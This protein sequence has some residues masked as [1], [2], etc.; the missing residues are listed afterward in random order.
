MAIKRKAIVDFVKSHGFTGEPKDEAILAYIA[1]N[2]IEFKTAKGEPIDVKS[3]LA[4][5]VSTVID[6]DDAGDSDDGEDENTTHL[7]AME[8]KIAEYE[9]RDA[10]RAAKSDGVAKWTKANAGGTG[11]RGSLRMADADRVAVKSYDRRVARKEA[12]YENGDTALAAGAFMR[13]AI[14][15]NRDYEMKARDLEI[16]AH[17]GVKT[18]VTYDGGLGGFTVPPE[19]I[20]TWIDLR[21]RY[22][23]ATSVLNQIDMAN[24]TVQIPRRTAGLTVYTPGEAG[25]ITP[26]DIGVDLVTVTTTKRAAA[27][28]ISSE[29]LNDSTAN[30]ADKMTEEGVYALE[31]DLEFAVVNGDATQTYFNQTGLVKS[32]E[33]AV[34]AAGGT[35][36][37]DSGN[38]AGIVNGSGNSWGGLDKDDF[39]KASGRL[40]EYAATQNA[41]W[42]VSRAYWSEVMQPIILAQ[43]GSTS[44][45]I[46]G[47][48]GPTFKGF[49]VVVSQAMPRVSAASQIGAFLGAFQL[50]G[51]VG[52]TRNSM[53]IASSTDADF[54]NDLV[55]Y[56]FAHR[57]GVCIHDIGN[58]SAT[59]AD[60]EAGPI[61][62]VKTTA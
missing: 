62:A 41:R 49:P 6:D 37:T 31:K 33:F 51:A 5:K 24:H 56:R 3:V 9:R 27:G 57:V 2:Q 14:M 35:W 54:L 15:G 42:L 58:Y 10:E 16:M 53:T 39:A 29:L 19:F 18:Q 44:G 46:Q 26:S 4:A 34:T 59:A 38:Q 45:D 12:H 48:L 52:R 23:G 47:A 36:P 32:F 30:F 55:V 28:K 7:K 61:V 20:P 22:G 60:R 1:E 40:P 21:E 43:G 50:G 11:S 8:A 17:Y 13:R 25:A